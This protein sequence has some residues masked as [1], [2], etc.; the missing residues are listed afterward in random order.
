[1][2]DKKSKSFSAAKILVFCVFIA[3]GMT[4][5]GFF[6][7][8]HGQAESAAQEDYVSGLPV[9]RV[10]IRMQNGG[11]HAFDLEIAEK[12]I[13]LQVGLMY[14]RHMAPDRGMLFEMGPPQVTQFW[15]ENTYIPLDMLFVD[16]H[17]K[18]V[19]LHAN[20]QPLSRNTISSEKPVTGVIEL[21]GGRAAELGI[22]VGDTVEYKY[23]Q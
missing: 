21:N 16:E 23:F 8:R 4:A 6:L 1:M 18:I 20:A 22:Q 14:R 7:Q 12:S 9:D 17:G 13:D 10:T 11:S 2:M 15:M 3:L 5:A 19:S